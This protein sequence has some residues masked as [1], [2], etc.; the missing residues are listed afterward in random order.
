MRPTSHWPL[1]PSDT[2][3]APAGGTLG[4]P[5]APV[6]GLTHLLHVLSAHIVH[7]RRL[8]CTCAAAYPNML[9][10]NPPTAATTLYGPSVVG[11]LTGAG[12]HIV[13]HVRTLRVSLV[14]CTRMEW[15][16]SIGCGVT[17]PPICVPL[18]KTLGGTG[19]SP[20]PAL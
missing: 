11:S 12:R 17:E 13:S 10:T 14:R 1:V 8:S 18:V 5:E 16:G 9:F 6:T 7:F 19:R 2:V 3:S 4:P 20:I 15:Q